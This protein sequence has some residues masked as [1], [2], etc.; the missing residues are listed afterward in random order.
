[1]VLPL[2]ISLFSAFSSHTRARF[3]FLHLCK[4]ISFSFSLCRCI[5]LS[6]LDFGYLFFFTRSQS[7]HFS[8]F[9]VSCSL[10][11]SPVPFHFFTVLVV[12]LRLSGVGFSLVSVSFLFSSSLFFFFL[13]FFSGEMFRALGSG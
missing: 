11:F 6:L 3:P 4:L 10:L 8:I 13:S 9:S 2:L 12:A 5:T 7:S 1:M